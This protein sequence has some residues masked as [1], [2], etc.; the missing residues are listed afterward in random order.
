MH[1]RVKFEEIMQLGP[2]GDHSSYI[3]IM[4]QFTLK[5]MCHYDQK[6]ICSTSLQS[7]NSSCTIV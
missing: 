7:A 1:I 4:T 5:L 2:V 3:L 6:S